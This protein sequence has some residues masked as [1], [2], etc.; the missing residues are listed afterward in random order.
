MSKLL[1]YSEEFVT[2][3]AEHCLVRGLSEKQASD[4]LFTYQVKEQ[5]D[6]G[7][8]TKEA[9]M[10]LAAA[11][12]MAG[13]VLPGAVNP[14][15]RMAPKL[16]SFGNRLAQGV[17]GAATGAARGVGG[18]MRSPLGLPLLSTG[19]GAA[20][21][22][23]APEGY[24]PN[25][26]S[27]GAMAGAGL[28][29]GLGALALAARNPRMAYKMLRDPFVTG[30]KGMVGGAVN[31]GVLKPMMHLGLAG[32]GAG[33]V[34]ASRTGVGTM[35]S[36]Y[37]SMNPTTGGYFDGM[38]G[39]GA[40]GTAGG[41]GFS[42][43]FELPSEIAGRISGS[44]GGAPGAAGGG[45]GAPM[46]QVNQYRSSLVDLDAKIQGLESSMPDMS[47]PGL[48]SQRLSMQSQ[49]DHMKQQRAMVNQQL[50][51]L[52]GDISRTKGNLL[53]S[54]ADRLHTGSQGLSA[55]QREFDALRKRQEYANSGGVGGWLMGQYNNITGLQD[56]MKSVGSLF[57]D[58][59]NQ[60]G[61]ARNVQQQ[62][63]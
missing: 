39:G 33:A 11:R 42:N 9:G 21:A 20:G 40:P 30:V 3:F 17:G 57:N 38:G 56:R 1:S 5:M 61:F 16:P 14:A 12:Q 32:A 51:A 54:A 24:G 47:N 53:T 23:A 48:Y 25:S 43:P 50:S 13:K 46:E 6:K 63:Q 34:G 44:G 37:P 45:F 28:G 60:V 62:V 41:S 15:M 49:L 35:G 4:L 10:G 18:I 27:S 7:Y 26:S 8:L 19:I 29:A 36:A 2:S 52:T 55:S 59:N 22:A 31:P 58:Y